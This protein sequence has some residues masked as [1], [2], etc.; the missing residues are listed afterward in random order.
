MRRFEH[1]DAKNISDAISALSTGSAKIIA[2]GT[3]LLGIMKFEILPEYPESLVNIK[4]IPDLDYI[5]E[6]GGVLKMG[7][8]TTLKDIASNTTINNKY[9]A[10]AQAAD[11]AASPN[12]RSMGTIGGNI[13]QET[14]CWYYRSKHNHFNCLKKNQQGLCYALIGDNRYHS[15]FGATNGC[16]CVNPSDLA[17]A[18]IA[19]GATVVTNKREI[20][21]ADFFDVKVAPNKSAMTVLEQDEIVTEIQVPTPPSGAKSAFVKFAIRK[22]IDFPIVNC[23]ALIGGG[24]TSI[25]MNAVAGKP[26]K[27]TTA[28][29]SIAGKEIN[30]ANATAA[31]E[32]A[33]KGAMDIGKNK[34]KIQIAKAMVKQAILACK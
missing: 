18:L 33:V 34:F 24:A 29:Q 8:L 32:E 27:A 13:C 1:I 31:A 14:R 17:P 28:E 25:C 4:A 7:A 11:R 23:A 12:L 10:L 22:S 16:V 26:R 2:G 3:D 6:E 5:Q 20:A 21:I 9:V 30:E 19:L 15:I